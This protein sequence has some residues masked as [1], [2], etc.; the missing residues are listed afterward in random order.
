MADGVRKT[1]KHRYAQNIVRGLELIGGIED[2]ATAEAD[3]KAYTKKLEE[4]KQLCP[5]LANDNGYQTQSV[6][7][8]GRFAPM[9]AM[10]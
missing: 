7:A 2:L 8:S 6:N 4:E 3:V 9:S 10:K 1:Y 5:V